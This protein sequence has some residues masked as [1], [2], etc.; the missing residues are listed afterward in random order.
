MEENGNNSKGGLF[1]QYRPVLIALIAGICAIICVSI[2]TGNI[3]QYKKNAGARGSRPPG[4]P[5]WILSPT[6]WCGGEASL[7]RGIHPG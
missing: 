6:L 7:C 5:A 1:L 4:R 3:I 2:F